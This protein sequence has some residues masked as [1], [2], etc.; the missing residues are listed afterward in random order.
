MMRLMALSQ[1]HR[2]SGVAPVHVR[3]KPEQTLFYQLVV[4]YWP[5]FQMQSSDR[6]LSTTVC[7]KRV[8]G[9]PGVWSTHRHIVSR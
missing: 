1:P 7:H 5:E 3:H 2:M 9:L 4:Q 6:S 8:R